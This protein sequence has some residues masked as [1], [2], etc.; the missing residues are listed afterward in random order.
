[1]IRLSGCLS[2][3]S[4]MSPTHA[5]PGC[6]AINFQAAISASRADGSFTAYEMTDSLPIGSFEQFPISGPQ[7][8]G[9]LPKQPML[10]LWSPPQSAGSSPGAPSQPQAF[11]RLASGVY[12]IVQAMGSGINA[13]LFDSIAGGSVR[14]VETF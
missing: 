11:A 8:T 10:P 7:L 5:Q 4:G 9:C 2:A 13:F 1:M 6:S 14:S 12:L 3:E